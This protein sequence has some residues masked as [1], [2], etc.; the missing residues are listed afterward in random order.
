MTM[1][2]ITDRDLPRLLSDIGPSPYPDYI[3]SVLA[4]T[5]RHRQRP[6]W[7]A[8]Q[9]WLPFDVHAWRTPRWER[10]PVSWPL[11]LSAMLL[12][13]AFVGAIL[14]TGAR[15]RDLPPLTG[16]ARNGVVVFGTASGEIAAFDPS[17]GTMRTLFAGWFPAF[18]NDGRLLLFMRDDSW[19]IAGPD[20]S[21]ARRLPVPADAFNL[22]WSPSG[23]RIAYVTGDDT[24]R[25]MIS[26]LHIEAG[27]SRT[28]DLG[29]DA[30]L[31]AEWRPNSDELEVGAETGSGIDFYLVRA[32][33]SNLRLIKELSTTSGRPLAWSPDGSLLAYDVVEPRMDGRTL[34][35]LDMASRLDRRVV[36]GE[37]YID[38]VSFSP[39]G[40]T[41]LFARLTGDRAAELAMVP[42]EGGLITPIGGSH[43]TFNGAGWADAVWSPDGT[44]ILAS[45]YLDGATPT[46]GG[47]LVGDSPSSWLLDVGTG[48]ARQLPWAM[49]GQ[50]WQRLAP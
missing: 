28:L 38:A 4:I 34:R 19:Y 26:I 39:D 12:V 7:T 44:Q 37:A 48:D 11:V 21:D 16:P 15:D 6:A 17:T 40:G 9:R 45:Y 46:G 10:L 24:G 41:L 18:S 35:I 1:R 25:T 33:G 43:R 27:V 13:A 3:D 23:D 5:E 8:P 36:H 47:E 42:V 20:G 31:V 50:T 29:L 22:K 30:H 2:H 49:Q 32:N 14:S